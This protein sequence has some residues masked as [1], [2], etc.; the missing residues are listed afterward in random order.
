MLLKKLTEA[1]GLPGCEDAVRNIII[2]EIKDHVDSYHVDRLGNLIAYKN[3]DADG[4]KIA[5]SA[6]MDEV[7]LIVK[8]VNG[9][10]T[11]AFDSWGVDPS[12]LGSKSVEV[13]EDRI[14]GIVGVKDKTDAEKPFALTDFFID[15][16]CPSKEE[17]EKLVKLG[18][19]AAFCSEYTEF[20]FENNKIKAKALDDR[21]GCYILI[22]LLQSGVSGNL[23]AVFCVQEEIGTRGSKAAANCVDVDLVIN[24][25][26]TV[27]LD[28]L[29]IKNDYHR[30][31]EQGKGIAISV[32]DSLS[33]YLK[34]Y[35]D[36]F[37]AVAK[38]H[39]L[40]CQ[41]RKTK[42]GGTDAGSYHVAKAGTP[43]IGLGVPCRYIHSPVSVADKRDI[44]SGIELV[45]KYIEKFLKEGV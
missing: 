20:G 18:D 44:E 39:N 31:T 15:I 1:N 36:S 9:D 24:V 26:G 19:Y 35:I 3:K 41:F 13:G 7:G 40:P 27:C 34:E 45:Q 5:L 29:N 21:I 25:E 16:G 42:M 10:G 4:R 17:A 37:T 8:G 28:V 32:L 11:L 14:K 33:I 38:E 2:E 6:H 23:T 12:V 30:V 22:K 43:V